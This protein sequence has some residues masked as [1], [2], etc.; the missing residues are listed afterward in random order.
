MR[1]SAI[2]PVRL[3]LFLSVDAVL[4][5]PTSSLLRNPKPKTL[6]PK[7]RRDSRGAP[8]FTPLNPRSQTPNAHP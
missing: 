3:V 5:H 4:I 6:N 2:I 1:L 7:P 8:E